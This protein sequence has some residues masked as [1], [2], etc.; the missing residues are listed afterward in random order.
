MQY[1][2][3]GYA[4]VWGAR[5]ACCN[6][7]WPDVCAQSCH[8]RMPIF[9]FNYSNRDLH[10][11]YRAVTDGTWKLNPA[12]EHAFAHQA[13]PSPG[14]CMSVAVDSQGPC[15]AEDR[16]RPHKAARAGWGN[17]EWGLCPAPGWMGTREGTNTQYPSQVQV[18]VYSQCPPLKQ[19]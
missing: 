12:G 3:A 14:I 13:S 6:A 10:G 17:R 9:L 16:V 5:P 2:K 7:A 19:A 8:C 18:E 11:I 1:I 4:L 15:V